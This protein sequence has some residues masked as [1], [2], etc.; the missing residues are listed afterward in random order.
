[1]CDCYRSGS[2]TPCR[3]SRQGGFTL[4]EVMVAF[5]VFALLFGVVLQILSTSVGNTR[6]S[7][8]YTQAAL[9]AQSKLDVLGLEQMIEPGVTQG[10]FDENYDWVME[11]NETEVVDE[12]GLDAQE[13][14]PIAL[15]HIRLTIEWGDGR[16]QAVFETLR[17]VDI[18]W[19]ERQMQMGGGPRS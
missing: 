6:L 15:Y 8:E 16:R 1:M 18:F 12:R 5:M 4:I 10:S 17:S 13:E 7:G 9:W 11:V 3:R 14:L 19:E 2:G